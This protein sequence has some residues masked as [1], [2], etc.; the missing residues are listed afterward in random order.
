MK[1]IVTGGAGF[2]GSH[3]VDLLIQKNYEVIVI[4]SLIHGKAENVNSKAKFYRMD[5]CNNELKYLFEE[6]KPDF[7]IHEAAQMSVPKSIENPINDAKVNII[8]SLNILEACKQS[9]VKKII[10][11]ASAAIFGEPEYLPIDENHKLNMLSQYGVS[12]HTVEHYLQV[13]RNLY[14]IEYTSLRCSNVYGP[15]QDS[16]GE[17]GVIAIFCEKML[18]GKKPIVFG[19]G[20]QIRDFVYVEDVAMA[21]IMAMESNINDIFNVCTGIKTSIND[22]IYMINTVLQKDIS[23]VYRDWRDGDIKQSWMSNKK[24][25][26]TLKWS[27]KY[28]ILE[29]IRKTLNTP[30]MV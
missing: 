7:V 11:P 25:M 16:S 13:Y 20:N 6:E 5:I 26:D 23:P 30:K 10:Y 27:P 17:G 21:S 24:I 9:N 19:N 15:R 29:G 14:G 8:G 12:K 22:L 4:D 1:V 2:I 18:E 3:I 28:T